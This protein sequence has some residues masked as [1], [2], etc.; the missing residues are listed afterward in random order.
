MLDELLGKPLSLKEWPRVG[1]DN[2]EW[3]KLAHDME[4]WKSWK[5]TDPE[6]KATHPRDHPILSESI[7]NLK[8]DYISEE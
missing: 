1:W 6:A 7:H 3:Y 8:K 4:T 2:G 5:L